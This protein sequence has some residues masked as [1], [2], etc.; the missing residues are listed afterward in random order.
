MLW[1]MS[2]LMGAVLLLS[3]QSEP[4]PQTAPPPLP[5]PELRRMS[6]EQYGIDVEASE[7]LQAY[8]V[9]GQYMTDL[10]REHGVSPRLIDSIEAASREVFDVRRMRAGRP[11]TIIKE[12]QSGRLQYFVYEKT[13]ASYV[14]FDLRNGVKLFERRKKVR[15]RERE[16]GGVILGSLYESVQSANLDMELVQRLEA[17]YANTVDFRDLDR[18]DFFKV[19]Y[20]EQL[21]DG[22][23]VGVGNILA[24]QVRQQGEDYFAIR[25][26][27]DSLVGYYNLQGR[28]LQPTFLFRPL[29]VDSTLELELRQHRYGND[30]LTEVGTPVVATAAGKVVDRGYTDRRGYYLTLRHNGVFATQ[31]LFMQDLVDSLELGSQVRQGEVLGFSGKHPE[32]ARPML[33]YRFFQAGQSIE[34]PERDGMEQPEIMPGFRVNFDRHQRLMSRRLQE[35]SLE[36]PNGEERV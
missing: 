27:Q 29:Q 22:V 30:F 28:S 10:L 7:V 16:A 36:V 32:F 1:L 23:P 26:E 6:Y 8:L 35:I 31:Y 15:L 3:C 2:W 19:V 14:V 4:E 12:N 21:V 17:L 5:S 20:E 11:I 24:A 18:G 34:P 9:E 13:D 25:F 33:R